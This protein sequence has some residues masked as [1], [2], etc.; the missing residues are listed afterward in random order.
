MRCA[1]LRHEWARPKLQ[2][3]V[4]VSP[5]PMLHLHIFFTLLFAAS[6]EI[7]NAGSMSQL[8]RSVCSSFLCRGHAVCIA[9]SVVFC[10]RKSVSARSFGAT[11]GKQPGSSATGCMIGAPHCGKYTPS[12]ADHASSPDLG[13]LFSLV[14]HDCDPKIISPGG[15]SVI[16]SRF[17]ISPRDCL[18]F[19]VP[20][21]GAAA[22]THRHAHNG[23]PSASG[24]R[25][26]RPSPATTAG[27]AAAQIQMQSL[28]S[29][30]CQHTAR[31]GEQQA[32]PC[33]REIYDA[34][35]GVCQHLISCWHAHARAASLQS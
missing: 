15:Y 22:D 30:M 16:M 14:Q 27:P 6:T 35:M 26:Y 8:C 12:R 17:S 11:E 31:V 24:L 18:H 9:P 1:A 25:T 28:L 4:L 2:R 29:A 21:A 3:R 33:A 32:T 13:L 5:L 20:L 10:G 34:S 7:Q 19:S 23:L